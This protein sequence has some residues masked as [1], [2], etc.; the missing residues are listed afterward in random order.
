M[1]GDTTWRN[2]RFLVRALGVC[3]A[4][5]LFGFACVPLY[6]I[7]CEHV[8]RN[9]IYNSADSG[10]G[11]TVDESRWVTVQF[12]GNVNSQLDWQFAPAWPRMAALGACALV[13][14][15]IGIAGLDRRIDNFDTMS[16]ASTQIG[17]GSVVFEP[18]PLTGAR[19]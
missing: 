8:F 2:R 7:A 19:P 9:K 14:F 16:V 6:R 13:G 5:F 17:L 15:F 18:E 12:V 4:M 3:G 10:K 11:F 1:S